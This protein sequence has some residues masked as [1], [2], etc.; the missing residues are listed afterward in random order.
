MYIQLLLT[1][2]KV[3]PYITEHHK[4]QTLC[5][6]K[7]FQVQ[8]QLNTISVNE[9]LV[10]QEAFKPNQVIPEQILALYFKHHKFSI[11]PSPELTLCT[12]SVILL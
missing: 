5:F 11:V 9:I 12:K 10:P 4:I 1:I 7:P 8:S 2:N 3:A 6:S